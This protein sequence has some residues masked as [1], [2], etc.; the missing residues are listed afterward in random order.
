M[1]PSACAALDLGEPGPAQCSAVVGN[2]SF[3]FHFSEMSLQQRRVTDR[4]IRNEKRRVAAADRTPANRS[5]CVIEFSAAIS[6]PVAA[7]V[8]TM[9]AP[10]GAVEGPRREHEGGEHR[11][12]HGDGSRARRIRDKGQFEQRRCTRGGLIR[13]SGFK[14]R[15]NQG[16]AKRRNESWSWMQVGNGG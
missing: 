1:S 5:P 3:F 14:V 10:T 2:V 8:E 11:D 7:E 16:E 6:E 13:R 4:S 12:G 9:R 15:V